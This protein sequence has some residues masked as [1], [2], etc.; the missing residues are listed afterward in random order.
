MD[1][2]L[3]EPLNSNSCNLRDNILSS[4][5]LASGNN[6]NLFLTFNLTEKNYAIEAAKIIEIVQLPQLSILEKAPDYIVGVMNLRGK[7]I[8]IVDMRRLLGISQTCYTIDHQILITNCKDKIIGV[9][10]DSVKDVITFKKSEIQPLPYNAHEHFISGIY[11]N[12]D[13]LVA[14]LNLDLLVEEISMVERQKL[15]VIPSST[16]NNYLFPTDAY[17][18]D[19]LKKRS[20]KLQRE[21]KVEA[22]NNFLD[23]NRF[24]SFT[25]NDEQYCIPLKHVKE[26]CKLKLVTLTTVP[27]VPEFITGIINLRGEFITIIDIKSFLQIPKSKTTDKTK[28][29]VIQSKGLQIGLV[30][31]DVFNIIN[32]PHEKLNH[33]TTAKFEQRKYTSAEVIFKGLG[34]MSVFDLEKF[35]E[36]ERLYIEDAI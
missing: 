22:T 23:E 18:Q 26:F 12:E 33:N 34:V 32:I 2:S 6:S 13:E 10:I 25:L 7:I 27:C 3:V 11:K 5:A 1:K 36:D 19:K 24:V 31:D 9:I 35:L 20:L 8:S 30:V 21:L 4:I 28:I 14:I 16:T 15:N 17:S 29:I